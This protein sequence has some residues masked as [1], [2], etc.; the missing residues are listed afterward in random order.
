MRKELEEKTRDTSD[1]QLSNIEE[2]KAEKNARKRRLIAYE[3]EI[4][5]K[6]LRM[7]S[8]LIA[9][10]VEER[11]RQGKTQQDIADIAGTF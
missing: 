8:E 4:Q 2:Y 11:K 1:L 10:L 3:E 6:T 5:K 7:S 9:E